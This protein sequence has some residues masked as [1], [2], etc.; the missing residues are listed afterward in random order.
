MEVTGLLARL[1]ESI[2]NLVTG[3][4]SLI[5]TT[6]GV[7]IGANVITA[8]QYIAIVLPGRMLKWNIKSVNLH[9]SI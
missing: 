1:L 2:M 7:C 9:L 4:S 3:T 8:D 6:L 5:I